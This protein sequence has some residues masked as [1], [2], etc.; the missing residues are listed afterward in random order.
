MKRILCLIALLF[1]LTTE[2]QAQRRLTAQELNIGVTQEFENFNPLIMSMMATTYM[3]RMVARTLNVLDENGEWVPQLAEVI[4]SLEN[5][6]ARRT[7]IDG[8][9]M[10]E[11]L[12]KIKSNASWGDGTPVTCRDVKFSWEVALSPMVSIS[13]KEIYDQVKEIVIDEKNPKDCLLRYR[14]AKWTYNRLAT[15]F[16]VPEHL[17]RPIFE[18][19]G[20]QAEGYEQHSNYTR[21]PTHPGLFN[22]PY[23][24]SE[25][26]L[27]SHVRFE[28]NPYF[29]GKPSFFERVVVKLI[30]NTGTLE[31]NLRSGTIDM[32][33][34]LGMSFDQ[35]IA[36]DEKVKKDDL[37]F[38]VNFQPSLVY[39]HIDFNLDHPVLK[40][41]VVRQALL[42]SIDREALTQGL[43]GGRQPVALHNTSPLDPWFTD[44]PKKIKIHPFS[45]RQAKR[46]LDQ[47]GWV[48][49]AD[50][51]RAKDGQRLSFTLMTTAGNRVR[52]LVQVY[53]QDQWRSIGADV[54]VKNEPARVFF[55]ETTRKRKFDGMA[56]YAWISS[57]ESNPRSTLSSKSIPSEENGWSGQNQPGWRNA[58]VDELVFKLDLEFDPEKRLAMIHEILFL[59]TSELPVLPLYYRSDVSVTPKSLRG[60]KL[61]GHQFPATNHIENWTLVDGVNEG[62]KL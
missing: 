18:Q 15:F 20:N 9:P 61:P 53:L 10:I 4:P 44:D 36:F 24:I 26:K 34:A 41:Q 12:W 42:M 60:Y 50:G 23:R 13:E 37:P 19:F 54:Q 51:V 27:G 1:S 31:A 38:D 47:H 6:L 58:R 7:T 57:P 22:G 25:I 40:D 32:V 11:A 46:L 2:L 8:H 33:S 56:M 35:A 62:A 14:E 52:E 39:E 29:Y 55:G 17:E 28:R 45:R 59:Y 48:V 43:F 49:A 5:G 21:N 30:P 16:I 3:Y